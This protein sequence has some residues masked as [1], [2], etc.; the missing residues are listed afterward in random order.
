[1][2]T[3]EKTL[4]VISA[5]ARF[6]MGAMWI[7]AGATKLGNRV[8]MTQIIEA[9]EI[10]TIEWSGFLA[11]I[12]GPLEIAGGLFLI[13]GLFLRQSAMVGTTVLVLFIIGIGQ[14]WGRGLEISCGC[15][16]E[17]VIENYPLEYATTIIRDIFYIFLHIWIFKRPFKRFALYP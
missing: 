13:L 3:K 4:E 11:V 8:Y 15:F 5:I 7:F 17:E 6:W 9:Y 2:S 12:I 16:G 10:F 14:A 1:M